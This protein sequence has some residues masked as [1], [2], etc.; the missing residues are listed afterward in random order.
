M[1]KWATIAIHN[2]LYCFLIIAIKGTN[3]SKAMT[4]N[5]KA[6]V[7]PYNILKQKD[8]QVYHMMSLYDQV[9][10]KRK[11]K[12]IIYVG[13]KRLSSDKERDE[14]IAE[15]NET[16]N[17][18]V[19]HE[20]S[21]YSILESNFYDMFRSAIAVIEELMQI[22]GSIQLSIQDSCGKEKIESL[23]KTIKIML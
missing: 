11:N 13:D 1:F 18:F 20:F 22:N 17:M 7:K 3:I 2:S 19:H 10:K 16:R 14:K 15:L 21:I 5:D 6:N 4:C 8:V 9:K 23:I 12:S